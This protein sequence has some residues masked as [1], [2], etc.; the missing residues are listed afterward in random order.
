MKNRNEIISL[1][2]KHKPAWQK[3]FQLKS[4]A[5]FG[6]Y[7]RGDNQQASDVDI[8][9]EVDPKIGLEFVDLAETIESTLNLRVDLVSKGALSQ[10]NWKEI[11][12]DLIYV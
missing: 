8:L 6:S 5:L 3:R 11:E 12:S 7:A 2:K 4:M 1:L 10:R 9:V